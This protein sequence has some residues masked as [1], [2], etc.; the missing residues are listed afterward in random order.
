L[1]LFANE[2]TFE[3]LGELG[4]GGYHSMVS[5]RDTERDLWP[6]GIKSGLFRWVHPIPWRKKKH[7]RKTQDGDS[8]ALSGLRV[9]AG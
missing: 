6:G 8:W 3:V 1:H 5:W 4:F 7:L 9:Q 2:I